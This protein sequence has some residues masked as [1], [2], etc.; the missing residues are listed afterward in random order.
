MTNDFFYTIAGISQGIHKEKSSKFIGYAFPTDNEISFK[1]KLAAIKKENTSASHFCYAYKFGKEGERTRS[2]DDGEP[3]GTAGKPILNQIESHQL[4]NL[5]VI[6]VRYFGGTLLGTSGLIQSYKKAA[7]LALNAA[8]RKK[9][10]VV[11]KYRIT[12]G[13]ESMNEVLKIC[14]KF[15]ATFTEKEL[16]AKCII[17]VEIKKSDDQKFNSEISNLRN[18]QIQLESV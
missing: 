13:F 18:S 15:Q 17:Q 10:F 3:S 4:T 8:E 11:S 12:F 2:S 16:L 14:K 1:E 7:E 9:E 6:V 5:A